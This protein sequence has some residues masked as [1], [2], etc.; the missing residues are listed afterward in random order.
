[1]RLLTVKRIHKLI[2]QGKLK[3]IRDV[4]GLDEKEVR[5]IYTEATKNGNYPLSEEELNECL[6]ED[7]KPL[8]GY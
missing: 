6:M 1:M 4:G 3:W 8:G 7:E 5:T 2:L